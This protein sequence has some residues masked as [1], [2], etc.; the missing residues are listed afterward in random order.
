MSELPS[1]AVD[2]LSRLERYLSP[3]PEAERRDIV[4]EIRSHLV[5]RAAQ[6]ATDLV[7][8]FGTPESYAAAFLQ[9]RE[10]AG[11][12][13][14]GSSWAIG[15]ALVSG[16]RKIG[17]WYVV[18][19]LGMLHLYGAG[20]VLLAALKP[21]FPSNVGMFVGEGLTIG[22]RSAQ[23]LSGWREVLGWWAIPGFLVPGV[24]VLWGA[25]ATLRAL[26]RWRLARLR[27][28]P[29]RPPAP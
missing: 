25:N 13:A 11:A 26:A 5:D 23:D 18:A 16:A 10:L 12:L 22:I 9:E 27:P 15:R 2:F 21:F 3:L 8:P 6:G 28:A 7:G 24:L 1:E 14:G 29:P 20:F 19:V 4:A 17:W